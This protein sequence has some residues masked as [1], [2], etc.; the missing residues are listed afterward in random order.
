MQHAASARTAIGVLA[1]VLLQLFQEA[2][3]VLGGELRVHGHDVGGVGEI[4]DRLEVLDRI[5]G[6]VIGAAGGVH[7]HR[8]HGGD[9]QRVAVG[10]GARGFGCADGAA[11]AALV[12][13]NHGLAQF[14]AHALRHQA[15]DDV[16]RAARRERNNHA[17]RLARVLVGSVSGGGAEGAGSA[18]GQGEGH[19]QGADF[20]H[21]CV[22]SNMRARV[23]TDRCVMRLPVD[24]SAMNGGGRMVCAQG[25]HFL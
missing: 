23:C 15:R 18:G 8:G 9:G 16:G 19:G 25:E 7:G 21:R 14:L 22:S 20:I 10:V 3:E 1:R 6:Q 2:L 13:H 5:V 24:R 12:F 17:D 11:S 4:G